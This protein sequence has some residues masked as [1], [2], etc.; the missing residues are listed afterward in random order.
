MLLVLPS[1]MFG[2]CTNKLYPLLSNVPVLYL[3]KYQKTFWFSGVFT[4]YKMGALVRKG[5]LVIFHNNKINKQV[6]IDAQQHESR[7]DHFGPNFVPFYLDNVPGKRNF[8]ET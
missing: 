5:L 4:G 6:W 2:Y 1:S 8:Q 3:W 7:K